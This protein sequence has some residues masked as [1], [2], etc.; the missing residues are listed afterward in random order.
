M[1]HL[2]Q[3][4]QQRLSG[5]NVQKGAHARKHDRDGGSVNLWQREV[6]SWFNDLQLVGAQKLFPIVP[7]APMAINV[8][9]GSL[10]K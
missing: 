6:R 2:P 4:R 9:V 8:T 5:I 3:E 1:K 10:A 7:E